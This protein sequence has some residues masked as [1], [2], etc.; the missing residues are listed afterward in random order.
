VGSFPRTPDQDV[1]QAV[2]ID[3]AHSQRI[4]LARSREA[5]AGVFEA[6]LAVPHKQ[7][8]DLVG[9]GNEHDVHVA[10]AVEIGRP[11]VLAIVHHVSEGSRN[12]GESAG[13][14]VHVQPIDTV[15]D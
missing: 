4:A 1:W 10:V 5:F 3:V 12:V 6:A 2:V 11:D 9:F 13:S 8:M 7:L 14:V 15:L